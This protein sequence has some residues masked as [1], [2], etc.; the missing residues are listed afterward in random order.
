M[1]DECLWSAVDGKPKVG[2]ELARVRNIRERPDVCILLD[3]YKDDWTQLW[4]IRIEGKGHVVQPVALQDDASVV[5]ALE[6]LRRKYPQYGK[7]PL[8]QR[9]PTL[10][11]FDS[12]H[13]RSWCA[14]ESGT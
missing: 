5:A 1:V 10:L 6:A 11:A 9:R 14:S 4:W 13:I 7:V 12:L 2:S 3:E 8:V